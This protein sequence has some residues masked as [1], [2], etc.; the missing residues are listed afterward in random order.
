[1]VVDTDEDMHSLR[2]QGVTYAIYTADEIQK[3]KDMDRDGL[4]A[5]HRVKEVFEDSK[6]EQVM[7]KKGEKPC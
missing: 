6:V 5:T 1:M 3:L 2:D 4:N 7:P